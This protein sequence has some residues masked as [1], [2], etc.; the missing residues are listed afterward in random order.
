MTKAFNIQPYRLSNSMPPS[1]LLLGS[2]TTSWTF[3]SWHPKILSPRTQWVA[4]VEHIPPKA[5]Q[6]ELH[7]EDIH[8]SLTS[9][10]S[11]ESNSTI[12]QGKGLQ[13]WVFFGI[14]EYWVLNLKRQWKAPLSA[15]HSL[16][17]PEWS[18]VS[19]GS[20]EENGVP[21][22]ILPSASLSPVC[23]GQVPRGI[24][25]FAGS[26]IQLSGQ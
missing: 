11:K 6:S 24:C 9:V 3:L 22:T 14:F 2:F 23:P 12:K 15:H 18:N 1:R 26:L 19:K 4:V 10:W 7:N 25:L 16:I 5:R 20:L 13:G 8:S 17:Q 21:F